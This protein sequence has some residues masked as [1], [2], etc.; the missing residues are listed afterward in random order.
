MGKQLEIPFPKDEFDMYEKCIKCGN[1][2]DT[3]KT[4]H[5]DFRIGYV[6]GAGQLCRD[7]YMASS[8]MLLTIDARTVTD[9][10][11]DIELGA[12]VREIYYKYYNSSKSDY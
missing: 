7:C 11:N 1:E 4:T 12:K 10:P 6:D 2:T 8:R 3:L 5:V 9:T